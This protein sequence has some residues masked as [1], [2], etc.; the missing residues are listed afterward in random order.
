MNKNLTLVDNANQ[1]TSTPPREDA[2]RL[3]PRDAIGFFYITLGTVTTA[4]AIGLSL[5]PGLA[6]WIAGQIL[7]ALAMIQWFAIL[8][9]AGHKT[10]FRTRRFNKWTAHLA[11]F[12]ALIPGDSWR[13][14]HAKHHYWTG[15]QD[16]DL[17]TQTLV[18][19]PLRLIERIVINVCWWCWIP[20][21]ATLYR[22][23]N[24][25]NVPRLW[26]L[27]PKKQDRRTLVANMAIYLAMYAL[28]GTIIGWGVVGRCMGLALFISFAMQDLIILSQ[29]THIPMTLAE[30]QKVDPYTPHEQDVFTRS[31]IFPNWVS[32]LLLLNMD[33][34]GLHH[35]YPSI[36][37]YHLHRLDKET[38]NCTP[39]WLWV[40]KAKS[41]RGEVL[42]FR[43]RDETGFYF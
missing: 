32:R 14:V 36:P 11:G 17:T 38:Q 7:L 2:V 18:P 43:N 10:L 33:A 20:L 8:H 30:G 27:F 13:I 24:Y 28:L 16:L 9:E 37:G 12:W 4:T 26:K 34:H 23:N 22:V 39:W 5:L 6:W 19:R 21:F 1:A 29:H 41:V 35:M 31:L 3:P 25:W 15:W 40:V 42:L